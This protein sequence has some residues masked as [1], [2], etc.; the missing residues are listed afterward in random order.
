MLA[1]DYTKAKK[2][3]K[4][5]KCETTIEETNLEQKQ[6]IIKQTDYDYTSKRN[7]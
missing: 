1:T 6:N 7:G 3:K 2:K 4:K 5:P